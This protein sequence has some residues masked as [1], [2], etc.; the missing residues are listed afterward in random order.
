MADLLDLLSDGLAWLV[1]LAL[2]LRTQLRG[3][4]VRLTEGLAL[5]A[6]GIATIELVV[7]VVW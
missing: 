6:G 2:L 7:R 1:V 3:E 4:R 5:V